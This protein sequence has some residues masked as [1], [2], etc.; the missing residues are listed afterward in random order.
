MPTCVA[1]KCSNRSG[2]SSNTSFFKF[3]FDDKDRLHHWISNINRQDWKP[4]PHSRLCSHHFKQDCF[5]QFKTRV[6]LTSDAVPTVFHRNSRLQAMAKYSRRKKKGFCTTNIHSDMHVCALTA[7]THDHSYI[8][9]TEMSCEDRTSAGD[10]TAKASSSLP[11]DHQ[12]YTVKES[13]RA[14]KRTI[15]TVQNRL[16]AYRKKIKKHREQSK[17]LRRKISSLSSVITTL[18]E[19]MLVSTN[20]ADMLE[21]TFGG[22]AKEILTRVN[23]RISL[24]RS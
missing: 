23:A 19:K 20:C 3:P 2:S 10:N 21:A 12:Q 1:L 11:V 6:C 5:I 9:R 22:V 16:A 13:P 8:G 15:W 18:R 14:L 17:R 7:V 4:T 24:A